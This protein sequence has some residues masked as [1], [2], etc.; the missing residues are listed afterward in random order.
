MYKQTKIFFAAGF[1]AI[2][3]AYIFPSSVPQ[4]VPQI[5]S[6]SAL[7]APS[8]PPKSISAPQGLLAAI[9]N[10]DTAANKK[11]LA[12]VMKFYAEDFKHND[13]ITKQ[14]LKDS[15]ELLWQRY[16]DISYR[17]EVVKVEPKGDTY[18]VE[19]I[20][21]I[22]GTQGQGE[23]RFRM[24]ATLT[25]LQTYKNLDKNLDAQNKSKTDN[26][27]I[28]SQEI[29]AEKSSLV[30]G[31]KPPTVELRLPENIG[32]G[33]QYALDAIVT[34]PLGSNLLLGAVVEEKVNPANYVKD[35]TIDLEAL[36]SGGIFKIG[37]APYSEGDRWIS[38]VL[39]RENG[40]TINSQRLRVSKNFVGGQYTP[41]PE[42]GSIR[43]RVPPKSDKQT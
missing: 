1:G 39:V 4:S 15:L 32:I 22:R 26:W 24:I 31:E 19:T 6:N 17:T 5:F 3:L 40:V 37:Q 25:S 2:A 16:K 20:T 12:S 9:A 8:T 28:V 27:Q 13:G 35:A 14:K 18:I 29:L 42:T 43:I 41:L 38:V 21:Q 36:K 10:L 7:A 34:E 23:S 30:S 33:R 11:D